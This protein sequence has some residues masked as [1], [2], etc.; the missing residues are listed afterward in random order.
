MASGD[1]VIDGGYRVLRKNLAAAATEE[2]MELYQIRDFLTVAGTLNLTRASQRCVVSQPALTDALDQGDVDFG[3]RCSPS[4][5]PKRFRT[6]PLFSEDCVVAIGDD[7]RFNGRRGVATAELN[8]ER[9]CERV[10]CE[11]SSYLERLLRDLSVALEVVQRSSRED[12]IQAFVRANVGI[13]FMPLSNA[14]AARLACV[15]TDDVPIVRE[16]SVMVQGERP[17]SAAQQAVI[18]ALVAHDWG[19]PAPVA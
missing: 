9:C 10:E 6:W 14:A 11:F 12:W 7:H 5:M 1:R 4:E 16:V 19:P 18:D 13:A 2:P 15:R 3:V 8:R 17:P